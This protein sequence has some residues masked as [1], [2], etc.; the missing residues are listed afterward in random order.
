M[1]GGIKS[2]ESLGDGSGVKMSGE[3]SGKGEGKDVLGGWGRQGE[4]GPTGHSQP[5]PPH[6][7]TVRLFISPVNLRHGDDVLASLPPR[8]KAISSPSCCRK[9]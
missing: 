6:P 2:P 4:T 7:Q 5:G 1:E 9:I 8:G 3:V